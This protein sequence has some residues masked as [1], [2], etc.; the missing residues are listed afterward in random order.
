MLPFSRRFLR[1]YLPGKGM[2]YFWGLLFLVLTVAATTTIPRFIGQG[3]DLI[4]NS[5]VVGNASDAD[6]LCHVGWQIIGLGLLLCVFRVLS[7]IYIFIPGRRVEAEIRQDYFND[8]I[9]IP[10]RYL[11]RYSTG[12]L[13]SRGTNDIDL[14]RVLLSMGILHTINSILLAGF[15]LFNMFQISTRLTVV[16]LLTLPLAVLV[17]KFLAAV[18]MQRSRLVQRQLGKLTE[19]IRELLRAH[20]L[21]SIYP[22]FNS[23][24]RRFSDENNAYRNRSENVQ[25]LRIIVTNFAVAVASL[26][27]FILMVVGGPLVIDGAFGIAEFVEYSVYLGLVQEPM[28]SWGFLISIFQRGEVCLERIYD[29]RDLADDV[30]QREAAKEVSTVPALLAHTGNEALVSIRDLR[31]H[32]EPAAANSTAIAGES[33]QPFELRI[34]ALDILRGRKYGIFGPI[35]SGKTTLLNLL[36]GNLP[37]PPDTCRFQGIDYGRISTDVL[38]KQFAIATQD[39]RH[40]DGSI[41]HNLDLIRE[42]GDSTMKETF[43]ATAFDDA[44]EVSQ[45]ANDLTLFNAGLDTVIGEHGIR[46]SGGQ[47]Q[48]LAILRALLKPRQVLVLDDIISAV[49][50]ETESRIL[51]ALYSRLPDET[52]III[53]H[54]ISALIPCDQILVMA[55]GCIVDRGTHDELFGRHEEYRQTYEHQVVEQQLLELEK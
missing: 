23:L 19:T 44:F 3:I 32:H 50:H 11:S 10:P 6:R 38:L 17:M 25:N 24:F 30:N 40:F 35:G 22:V 54:R 18:M 8:A 41:G 39:N 14:A 21:L 15:C 27:T 2:F 9:S 16:C 1:E 52:L 26:A 49:D 42:H 46:L 36:T 47:R 12:D 45:L 4:Q 31:F 13:V 7:R 37:T 53:S 5:D 48:R 20:T 43:Q 33:S 55:D 29:I 51:T 28:R 34:D